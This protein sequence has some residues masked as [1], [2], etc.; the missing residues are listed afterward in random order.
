[1]NERLHR[2]TDNKTLITLL[3]YFGSYPLLYF[4]N[5]LLSR[6]LGAADYGDFAVTR[7]VAG[8]GATFALLGMDSAALRYLSVYGK[9]EDRETAKGFVIVAFFTVL[10]GGVVVSLLIYGLTEFIQARGGHDDH[11]V[12]IA[13]IWIVP[14]S[15]G[16]FF[17][18]LLAS[19]DR[20]ILSSFLDRVILPTATLILLGGVFVL[21]DSLTDFA[22]VLLL[23]ASRVLILFVL[24]WLLWLLWRTQYRD[25]QPRYRTREWFLDAMPFLLSALVISAMGQSGTLI[26]EANHPTETEVGLFAAVRQVAYFPLIALGAVS[27]LA[28]PELSILVKEQQAHELDARLGFFV[29]IL[30]AFGVGALVV[31]TIWGDQL[32]R[33]FG[34]D[35]LNGRL[36]LIVLGIGYLISLVG[37][38]VI[39]LFHVLQRRRV[40][41][42]AM[43]TL[44]ALNVGLTYL[45]APTYGAL[46][47][48]AAYTIAVAIVYTAQT[49]WLQR[50]TDIR[51]LQSLLDFRPHAK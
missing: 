46:G 3:V 17:T 42:V 7:S 6:E 36:P 48:A 11:P 28:A 31:F 21:Q 24:I 1:M 45:L 23:V 18:R 32:I 12:M 4:M 25:A 5:V 14:L 19:H 13:A 26:L 44:L 38:L 10:A 30:A 29:R 22:A 16:L 41:L 35:F 37:G 33:L 27:L 51:Y 9:E 49:F 43:I 2:L 47:A 34:H 20:M 8:L 39:P 50:T 15:L 40:V